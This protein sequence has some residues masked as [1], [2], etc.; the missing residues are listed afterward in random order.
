MKRFLCVASGALSLSTAALS[1]SQL[2]DIPSDRYV[3]P[4]SSID[5]GEGQDASGD[6]ASMTDA[7]DN[8]EDAQAPLDGPSD[9]AQ[10]C[11]GTIGVRVTADLLGPT[12]VVSEP[13]FFGHYD[14]LRE[15]NESGG[16]RG[17]KLDIQWQEVASDPT[18]I[19]TAYAE[20]KQDPS[21][22]TVV[23][24]ITGSTPETL[25]ITEAALAAG[26]KVVVI[27]GS[28]LSALASPTAISK[29]VSFPEM[30]VDFKEQ[31][32]DTVK[33][34]K[35]YPYNFYPG[36]DYATGARIAMYHVS[37]QGGKRVGFFHCTSDYCKSPL[38]AAK[39][40]AVTKYGLKIGRDLVIEQTD[41]AD[42]IETNVLKYF[43]EEIDHKK[44]DASYAMVDWVWMGNTTGTTAL[45][46]RALARVR[47]ELV[48][49][50]NVQMIVN[51]WG[52][53]E[54]LYGLCGDACVDH[55]H[56]IAPI[57]PYGDARAAGMAAVARIHDKWRGIDAQSQDGGGVGPYQN[58]R[59]VTGFL[60]V[61][62]LQLA[63]EAVLDRGKPVNSTEI[64]AALESF[65][66]VAMGG[67]TSPIT[68]KPTDHRPQSTEF[69]YKIGADGK[70]VYEPP[71]R[72]IFLE[73]EWLGW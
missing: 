37:M 34:S 14:H 18:K 46:G 73:E 66:D 65:R 63:I 69:I 40:T 12:K 27:S 57:L 45:L 44:A 64:K 72:T 71:D 52:F 26:D 33:T 22:S 58:I 3:V 61:K 20:W 7:T 2:L 35:G 48:P 53:D 28:Y 17:C 38:E 70:L 54:M 21:W 43:Q 60:N 24:V 32:F 49:K 15:I 62:L 11:Q 13:L 25:G 6:P 36:T 50:V 1:C 47:S 41:K 5:A 39:T 30:S 23:S 42:V 56:G 10:L 68:F 4:V 9:G 16:I 51:N 8:T 31:Q 19:G 55:V 29:K 67:L 59:Y